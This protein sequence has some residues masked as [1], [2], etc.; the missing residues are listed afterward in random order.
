MT[1]AT[2]SPRRFPT[3]RPLAIFIVGSWPPASSVLQI[4]MPER[5]G[6]L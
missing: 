1:L 5:R 3:F 2:L 4:L 6:L